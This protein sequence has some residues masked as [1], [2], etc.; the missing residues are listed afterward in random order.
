M[1]MNDLTLNE[2]SEGGHYKYLGQ[3]EAV[4]I[5]GT[6]NKE[7]VTSEYYKRVRKIWNSESINQSINQ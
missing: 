2:L 4:G 3:N 6:L 1:K 5:D 7:R